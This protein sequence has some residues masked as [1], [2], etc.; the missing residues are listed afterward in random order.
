MRSI[1][2]R[3]IRI[4]RVLAVGGKGGT[5]GVQFSEKILLGSKEAA[6]EDFLGHHNRDNGVSIKH[7]QFGSYLISG[8]LQR[9]AGGR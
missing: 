3:A 5:G 6:F 9:P 2:L 8:R 4:E 7:A 1:D